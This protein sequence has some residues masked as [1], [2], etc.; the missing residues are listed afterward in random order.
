MAPLELLSLLVL[1]P[2]TTVAFKGF[3]PNCTLPSHAIG[4]ATSPQVRGTLTIV[5]SCFAVIILCTWSVQHLHVP[6]DTDKEKPSSYARRFARAAISLVFRQK[7]KVELWDEFLDEVRWNYERLK[8]MA[9]IIL[10]PEFYFAKALTENCAANDSRKGFGDERWGTMHAFHANNRGF[11]LRFETTAVKTSLHPLKADEDGR[12]LYV[13]RPDGFPTT[14]F[15]QDT[16]HAEQIEI[17][18]CQQKC[19]SQ[20]SHRTDGKSGEGKKLRSRPSILRADSELADQQPNVERRQVLKGDQRPQVSRI[21]TTHLLSNP[22]SPLLDT[23]TTLVN[24][25]RSSSRSTNE[26]QTTSTMSLVNHSQVTPYPS[27]DTIE[28]PNVRSRPPP[29]TSQQSQETLSPESPLLRASP[30]TSLDS[31][32]G[33]KTRKP[34]AKPK[35]GVRNEE[36]DALLSP[37]LSEKPQIFPHKPWPGTMSLN[38]HQLEYAYSIRLIGPPPYIDSA[39][40]KNQSK[41]DPLAKALTI[42]QILWLVIQIMARAFQSPPLATTLLEVTV[43]AFAACAILIYILLWHKPQDVK[44]PTYIDAL[45]PITRADVIG[46]AAR[47]P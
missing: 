32:V 6:Q 17:R 20:C 13:P 31:S 2:Q 23:S 27:Q 1:I 44:V 15:E 28:L 7:K 37:Q 38:T 21:Q 3:Q 33:T 16:D 25:P 45:R 4:Y 22:A 42:W 9:F 12:A 8:W 14:Y 34:P 47:A 19:G 5:W 26:I 10:V 29:K 24:S 40:L 41:T 43:L 36:A 39:T 46:L 35:L 11:V 18:H 30:R